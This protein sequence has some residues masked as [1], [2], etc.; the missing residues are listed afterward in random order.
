MT[1][2]VAVGGGFIA[3]DVVR[4][5]EGVFERRGPKGRRV[6]KAGDRVMTAE[7]L[8]EA[9]RDGW[10][11]LKVVG[12]AVGVSRIHRRELIPVK[13]GTEIKRA[14]KTIVKGNPERLLWSDENVRGMVSSKFLGG[15]EHERFMTMETD[16]EAAKP[17]EP[18]R[19]AVKKPRAPKRPRLRED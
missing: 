9:D 14:Y 5:K 18:A 12:C 4:W 15:K 2:W 3:A 17:S 7:V 11:L 8:K 1:E 10:V 16:E 19:K 13:A 6:V